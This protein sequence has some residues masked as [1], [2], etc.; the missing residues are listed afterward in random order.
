MQLRGTLF[1]VLGLLV[2]AVMA[3]VV[4][5]PINMSFGQEGG[6]ELLA[7]KKPDYSAQQWLKVKRSILM[8]EVCAKDSI[9]PCLRICIAAI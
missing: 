6:V 7:A 4:F 9:M 2:A 3:V 8:A 1:S 5:R